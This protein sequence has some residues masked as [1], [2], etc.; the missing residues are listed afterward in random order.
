MLSTDITSDIQMPNEFE[1]AMYGLDIEDDEAM[2]M[3]SDDR[4]NFI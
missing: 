3:S 1:R 2:V 4:S